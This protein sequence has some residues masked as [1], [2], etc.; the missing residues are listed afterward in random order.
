VE[1]SPEYVK[2]Q[3]KAIFGYGTVKANAGEGVFLENIEWTPLGV[4]NARNYEDLSPAAHAAPCGVPPEN[5][6]DFIHSVALTPNGC[7]YDVTFFSAGGSG[8]DAKGPKEKKVMDIKTENSGITL[9]LL[10]GALG[11]AA[12]AAEADVVN[13][14][15]SLSALKRLSALDPLIK[16][17]KVLV[18]DTVVAMDTRL[19]AIETASTRNVALLSAT[20]DGKVVNFTGEDVVKLS[21]RLDLLQTTIE[22]QATELQEGERGR[23]V[24]LFAAEGKVP[25]DGDGKPYTSEALKKLDVGTLKLLH[26]NTPSTVPLSA[27]GVNAREGG[28]IDPNLK[29]RERFIAAQERENAR[30]T[31]N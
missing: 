1:G 30:N 22:R 9:A 2:G 15:K 28:G 23:L 17:G 26:A 19:K 12:E 18:L 20:V 5:Q 31:R 25:K 29:G 8:A 24:T 13:E 3:P 27:R 16:D 4:A 11:L 6:V 21:A 7:L 14:I 10:A